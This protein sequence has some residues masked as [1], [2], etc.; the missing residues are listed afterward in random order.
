[1]CS[2]AKYVHKSYHQNITAIKRG[3]FFM[4]IY[5]D[6][7][8]RPVLKRLLKKRLEASP[9]DF[10]TERIL[11]AVEADERRLEEMGDCNHEPGNYI[12]EK[13]CCS[14][15]GSFYSPGMG[16]GWTLTDK[17]V[18]L[19]ELKKDLEALVADVQQPS[20]LDGEPSKS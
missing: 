8:T 18:N 9:K 20:L 15:C 13:N 12:G 3:G 2:Y 7:Q 5:L 16:E 17:E 4:A 1:M 19:N 11:G 14:K 6:N 10:V